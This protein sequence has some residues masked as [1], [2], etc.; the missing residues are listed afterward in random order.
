M[1]SWQGMMM[2][3]KSES[4]T[5]WVAAVRDREKSMVTIETFSRTV[6]AARGRS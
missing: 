1:L 6:I 3:K 2:K 4:I 5:M